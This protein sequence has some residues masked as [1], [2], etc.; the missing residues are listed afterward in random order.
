MNHFS[1][2]QFE[3]GSDRRT[4][5]CSHDT[6]GGAATSCAKS[7]QNP[8]SAQTSCQVNRVE[9]QVVAR[10]RFSDL[11]RAA[12]PGKTDVAT[13]RAAAEFLGYSENM[14]KNWLAQTHSPPFDVVF[15]IG[16]KVGVFKVMEVM[17]RGQS[18]GEV[19][20]LIVKGGVRRVLRVF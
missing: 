19:L 16:C 11:L 10:E 14:V 13:Y 8:G 7:D 17:T 9:L 6:P 12:F 18:R 3:Q 5:D 1:S 2:S 15:A 4:A 20:G